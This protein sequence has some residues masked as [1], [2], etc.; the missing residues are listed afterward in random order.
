MPDTGGQGQSHH[1]ISD[2][3]EDSNITS[4]EYI[5]NKGNKNKG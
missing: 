4:L 1:H 3:T 2:R 5:E